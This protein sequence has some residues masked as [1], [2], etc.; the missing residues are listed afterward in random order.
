[1]FSPS[2]LIVVLGG[3]LVGLGIPDLVDGRA[4]AQQSPTAPAAPNPQLPAAPPPPDRQF[5][6]SVKDFGAVGDGQTDDTQALQKAIDGA[7]AGNRSLFVPQGVYRITSTLQGAGLRGMQFENL[8]HTQFRYEGTGFC[9]DLMGTCYGN[10]HNVS[11]HCVPD[12]EGKRRSS[13]ILLGNGRSEEAG[14]TSAGNDGASDAQ[15]AAG[16][17]FVG[18][19]VSGGK[20]GL[21]IDGGCWINYFFQ[22]R[23]QGC[24]VGLYLGYAANS[25]DFF[26]PILLSNRIG[27]QVAGPLYGVHFIGGLCEENTE[28]GF[29]FSGAGTEIFAVTI[30]SMYFEQHEA[31][32]LVINGQ[33]RNL[34][35]RDCYFTGNSPQKQPL[36]VHTNKYQGSGIVFRDNFVYFPHVATY[37]DLNG[38]TI[39]VDNCYA[40]T[41]ERVRNGTVLKTVYEAVQAE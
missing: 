16:N 7:R 8:I 33:V 39:L 30:A 12:P 10:F 5:L 32:D 4:N 41:P 18:L 34:T 15:R 6:L 19:F 28:K 20:I 2:P 40:F 1:M 3:L 37:A 38:A 17:Y 14:E 9:L 35:V 36:L 23:I 31:S 29:Y 26:A 24:D 22:P 27:V 25:N 11:I 21:R 13:G